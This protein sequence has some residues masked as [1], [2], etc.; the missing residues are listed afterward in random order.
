MT[1]EKTTIGFC[2]DNATGFYFDCA[3]SGTGGAA[4]IGSDAIRH[5]DTDGDVN[6]AMSDTA[7]RRDSVG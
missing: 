7:I 2:D 4:R 5:F 6:T 1:N 3:I